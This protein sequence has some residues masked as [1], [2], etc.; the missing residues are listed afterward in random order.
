MS[1]YLTLLSSNLKIAFSLQPANEI[2]LWCIKTLKES[3][4]QFHF[5]YFWANI[6]SKYYKISRTHILV[7]VEMY[8]NSAELFMVS[9]LWLKS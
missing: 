8:K 7:C 3:G 4:K 6:V 5:L 9:G 1:T 2:M